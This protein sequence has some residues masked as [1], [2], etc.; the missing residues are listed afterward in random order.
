MLTTLLLA[1]AALAAPSADWQSIVIIELYRLPASALSRYA[2]H[3]DPEIRARAALALGRLKDP[4]AAGE[5]SNLVDDGDPAVRGAAAFALGLTPGGA[6]AARTALA[7]EEDPEVR[8]RLLAALG[9]HGEAGDVPA[10]VEGLQASPGEAREAAVA[11]GRLGMAGLEEAATA[12]VL[13]GLAAQLRRLDVPAREAA[14]FALRRI[15]APLGE[16]RAE[17]LM[18]RLRSEP[19][20]D[21]RASLVRALARAPRPLRDAALER[22]ARDPDVGVRASAAFAAAAAAKRA[23]EAGDEEGAAHAAARIEALLKDAHWSV[24]LAAIQA[25]GAVDAL[26]HRALLSPFL[27]GGAADLAAA[28]LTA[29]GERD[30]LDSARSWLQ[31]T[32]PILLQAAA[33]ATLADPEQLQRLAIDSPDAPIRTAA[34]ARL[35]DLGLEPDRA[36]ALLGVKDTTVAAA[37]ASELA[38]HPDAGAVAPLM[39]RL[40]QGYEHEFWVEAFR[41]LDAILALPGARQPEG[42]KPLTLKALRSPDPSVR[43]AA[44]GVAEQ[45]GIAPKAPPLHFLTGLPPLEELLEIRSARILTDA[46]EIRL[47]LEPEIAPITVWNFAQLAE[48]GYFDGLAFHR[49]VPDFVI[50]D[51]CPRGDGWGGPGYAIPDELSWLP[52]DEGAVGMALSGPDTGGSQW[53][54]TL[55]PQPHLEAGYT[56]FGHLSLENGAT[57]RV[58][59]GTV[60]RE[61][62]IERVP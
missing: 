54:V 42:L 9:L 12:E 30:A 31:P 51:G 33:V 52:Y 21:V 22:G 36:A 45:L 44:A 60:I 4:E 5:L 58:R 29:L 35:I 6:A 59:Q 53:F 24:Q 62:I 37:V 13:D 46:G 20:P 23:A 50:Q 1:S 3:E 27:E 41:A 34:V 8:A 25:A 48:R 19:D 47:T 17:L 18:T 26:D 7:D 43:A 56:V 14:A 16:A 39:A 32:Q 38:E 57:H 55:S 49:V 10:L 61:V 40:E 15:D 28:A 11:L 2:G